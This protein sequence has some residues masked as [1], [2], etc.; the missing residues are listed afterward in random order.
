MAQSA[1]YVYSKVNPFY[2]SKNVIMVKGTG[3]KKLFIIIYLWTPLFSFLLLTAKSNINSS[4]SAVKLNILMILK[5]RLISVPCGLGNNQ[6]QNAHAHPGQAFDIWHYR[7]CKQF[8]LALLILLHGLPAICEVRKIYDHTG[9]SLHLS[10]TLLLYYAPAANTHICS[11]V[12][13]IYWN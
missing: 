12:Y 2:L 5:S 1:M 11:V 9:L 4:Q 8:K 13:K 10:R 6:T 3:K 7:I